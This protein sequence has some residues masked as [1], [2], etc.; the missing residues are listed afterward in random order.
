MNKENTIK[1]LFVHS[2]QG[3]SLAEWYLRNAV[4]SKCEI[5]V[6]FQSID[7]SSSGIPAN[8]TLLRNISYF[9]PD[10]VGFSCHYWSLSF[11]IEASRWV[12][13]LHPKCIIILGGPQTF[14][15][16][17][18]E[19][20]L[21]NHKSIDLICRGAGE[22]TIVRVIEWI[23]GKFDWEKISNLSFRKNGVVVHNSE[24]TY[25]SKNRGL[26]FRL[27]NT[28]LTE[29]L[30]RFNEVS[31]ETTAGCYR[32]CAYC[33]YPTTKFEILDD[34]LVNSELSYLCSLKIPIIRICDT[35]FGGEKN[36]AKNILHHL[37]KVNKSSSIKIYPDVMH[38]DKEYL[39]L[40]DTASAEI[41]SIGIQTTCMDTLKTVHRNNVHTYREQI[42]LILEK[43]PSVP[44]DLIIGLPGEN[45]EI[46]FKTFQDVL[47][48]GFRAVNVFRLMLFPGT[49]LF[50]NT[51]K[52]YD[53]KELS[54]TS[55][56]Q[57][58]SSQYISIHDQQDITELIYSLEIS[59]PL[60]KTR[61]VLKNKYDELI[62]KEFK[63]NLEVNELKYFR[64][65]LAFFS[66]DFNPA[67]VQFNSSG[68]IKNIINILGNK[69]HVREAVYLDLDG[70]IK[71]AKIIPEK[72][73]NIN[74]N[75]PN[76]L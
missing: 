34:Y 56:G 31:Y 75:S 47:D 52:Y 32:K 61:K 50:E 73:N 28:Q 35:H 24:K 38:I 16:Y 4:E 63:K 20:I 25:S 74:H 29:Q 15:I 39:E 55:Q 53:E 67:A 7:I 48:L 40:I 23:K 66:P 46:I 9:K 41:T 76:N 6:K 64:N 27:E 57:L 5:P 45:K 44:A 2:W 69:P 17:K 30:M 68:L 42:K 36:R 21:N 59:C 43:F 71:N 18:A 12:K 19:E 37:I 51:S 8:D 13:H 54:V 62:L 10:L 33:F 3:F 1:F 58:L 72:F 49:E 26:I 22:E 60:L 65:S 14:S 70:I 11:F